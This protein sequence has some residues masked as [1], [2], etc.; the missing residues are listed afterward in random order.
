MATSHSKYGILGR[1]NFE[2]LYNTF[3]GLDQSKQLLITGGGVVLFIILIIAPVTCGSAKLSKLEKDYREAAKGQSSIM[4]RIQAYQATKA[5]LTAMKTKLSGAGGSLSTL[6]ENM[7]KS[8][9]IG[10]QVTRLKPIT[11]S[12]NDYF[13]EEGVDI[14]VTNVTIDKIV[15]FLHV[16]ENND[17]VPMQVKK[18][19]VKA[20]Y[21]KREDLTVTIEIATMKAKGEEVE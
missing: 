18:L 8:A 4:E 20:N 14:V 1:F 5:K 7:A 13:D 10:E 2:D 16:V 19:Q 21:K 17:K 15:A 3:F 6:V 11:L 12:S 9:E